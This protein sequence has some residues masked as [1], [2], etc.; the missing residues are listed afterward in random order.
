MSS[1]SQFGGTPSFHT[2]GGTP[3]GVGTPSNNMFGSMRGSMGG[4]MLSQ[5]EDMPDGIMG[6]STS[7]QQITDGFR[8]V[9]VYSTEPGAAPKYTSLIRDAVTLGE[10]SY[11]LDLTDVRSVAPHLYTSIRVWPEDVLPVVD[12][13]ATEVAKKA[14]KA[15]ALRDYQEGMGHREGGAP[16]GAESTQEDS[17]QMGLGMP[18]TP[19]GTQQDSVLGSTVGA[20]PAGALPPALQRALESDLEEYQMT[21]LV[22]GLAEEHT[23]CLRTLGPESIGT[24]ISV[25]GMVTKVSPIMPELMVATFVCGKCNNHR[26][27][28]VAFGRVTMPTQCGRCQTRRSFYLEHN[29]SVFADR[30]IIRLQEAPDEVAPGETPATVTLEAHWG[31]VGKNKPGD[32]VEITGIYRCRSIRVNPNRRSLRAVYANYIDLVHTHLVDAKGSG[33]ETIVDQNILDEQV[34]ELSQRPDIYNVL[35]RSLAPSIFGLTDPKRGLLLQLLGGVSKGD[36]DRGSGG[37]GSGEIGTRRRGELN[38]LLIGDPGTAKSQLLRYVHE[39]SPRGV[40]T[41]GKGSSAVGLTAYVTRDADTGEIVL[42]SGALVLSDG[43][44]CCIDE[45]DKMEEGTRTILHEALEQQTISI[46]KAGIV[47]TLNARTAVLAAANPVMSRYD[48]RKSVVENLDLPPTLLSRFDL[49]YLI[50]DTPSK[51]S[52]RKLAMHLCGLYRPK[53]KQAI[54]EKL[55]RKVLAAYIK[56]ARDIN[57][58]LTEQAT[59]MLV[60]SYVQLRSAGISSRTVSATPRQLESLIRLSEASARVRLSQTVSEDDVREALRLVQVALRHSCTDPETGRI[61]LDIL[62]TGV[63]R[64]DRA[65]RAALA[66]E[67]N[68]FLAK[69]QGDSVRVMEILTALNNQRTGAGTLEIKDVNDAIDYLVGEGDLTRQHDRVVKTL[70]Y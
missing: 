55:D 11:I 35:T 2:P 20:D 40:Y 69:T 10:K 65:Q 47:T 25:K 12:A 63:S 61:D 58:R 67:V 15:H 51:E 34:R 48:P 37:Q 68:Q 43:G 46:A 29:L 6:T 54:D 32:R 31:L 52:D 39:L 59:R 28:Q 21:T 3:G 7:M 49:I 33:T 5:V 13:L 24:L 36:K 64:H 22:C 45:L 30:Q 16:A 44:V 19:G 50:L 62:S 17:L 41:S 38:V 42:E 57:P 18:G 14:L 53:P 26:Q 8:R 60:D 4:S 1:F 27:V 23:P 66:K 9:L 70:N 56:A